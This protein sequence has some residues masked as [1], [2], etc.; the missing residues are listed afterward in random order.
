M[1]HL[2]IR[3]KEVSDL[4]VIFLDHIPDKKKMSIVKLSNLIYEVGVIVDAYSGNKKSRQPIKQSTKR[5]SHAESSKG[6][7]SA[8][9]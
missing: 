2:N 6:F 8:N 9:L 5:V 7:I 3:N 4:I 1:N